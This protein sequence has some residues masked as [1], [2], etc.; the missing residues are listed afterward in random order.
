MGVMQGPLI[1]TKLFVPKLRAGVVARPRL[2]DRLQRGGTAK[3]TLVSAP[4]GFGKTTAVVAWLQ[5]R[6]SDG[7]AVAWLSL[8]ATDNQPATFWAHLIAALNDAVGRIG[9]PPLDLPEATQP[10]D[11]VVGTLINALAALSLSLE[12]VLD[13]YHLIEQPAVNE[14]VAFLLEHLPPNI[15]MVMTARADPPLPLARLRAQGELVEVRAADLRFTAD[16]IATYLNGALGLGLSATEVA[17]LGDRTEG[18]IA[19]LQLAALSIEGREDVAAF[20]AGFAG[21]DRYVFDYLVEEVLQRQPENVRQF[22]LETCFLD[23]L[24]GALCDAVIGGTG[25]RQMLEALDRT[26][27]FV[28]PLDDRREW[29]RY[30][31]LFADVLETQLDASALDRLRLLR[32]RASD[33]YEASGERGAAIRY[34]LAAQDFERAAELIELAA[35]AMQKT[36]QERTLRDWMR[37]LPDRLVRQRPVLGIAFAGV[38]ASLGE[39]E[40]LEDRLRNVEQSLA[41]WVAGGEQPPVG[42]VVV[43]QAQLPRVAGLIELYRAALGQVRGD[44]PGSIRHAENVLELAPADDHLARAAAASLLG[45]S[46]WSE[47]KLEQ[48][49]AA[50]TAGKDGLLR[51]GHLADTLGVSIALGDIGLALG[52]LREA[53]DIFERALE[54]S[55]AERGPVLRGTAD[56]HTGLAMV[57]RERNQLTSARAHLLAGAELGEAAGLPQNPYRQRVANALLQLDEGDP[58][59]AGNSIDEAIRLY[60]ADFFPDVRPLAATRAR[61]LIA[62]GRLD[63]AVHW[64]RQAGLGPDAPLSYL[65]EYEHITLAR[66]LIAQDLKNGAKADASALPLLHRL[67]E[68][69]E[70]GGRNGSVIELSIL[71]AL[72]C[73]LTGTEEALRHLER[74]LSLAA[75]EGHVRIFVSEGAPMEALLK[76]VARRQVGSYASALLLAFGPPA[77]Q[78]SKHPDQIE[79]LSEREFDVLRLL[80]TDL[81]GPE[82]ARQLAI[83]ENTM[84]T[85]TRNIYD[86]LGVNSRRAAVSR[87][88]ELQLLTRRKV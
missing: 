13:D 21:N 48:A 50:W 66:L 43:D 36:R 53:G 37:S 19:A 2:N 56:M 40:G 77:P 33:W 5:S 57:L 72:A 47:G 26:N 9:A 22:L 23:R 69:A 70:A 46:Y 83:S 75:P 14:G 51:A 15:H 8:D 44:L 62:E 3:L 80:A 63:E 16:E 59:S 12:I 7:R 82:I 45:I 32:R 84:R 34:A 76:L 38:L 87:A 55:A 74:A 27:L 42:I 68:A 18:W 65:R 78:P 54:V 39:F 20:I 1:A 24:S 49:R 73:R 86:K 58:D 60:V 88:E 25:S 61:I 30:H 41:A 28:V 81:G 35:F 52:R 79:A 11:L 4:A 10:D 67:L 85:H 31:H 71:L 17:A 6:A 64:Q 29:Y